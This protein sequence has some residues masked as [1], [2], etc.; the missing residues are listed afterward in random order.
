M[1]SFCGISFTNLSVTTFTLKFNI[2]GSGF[3]SPH[4]S[5]ALF[6]IWH[7]TAA[8]TMGRVSQ[9]S[10]RSLLGD[11]GQFLASLLVGPKAAASA[12]SRLTKTSRL[13]LY[14]LLYIIFSYIEN[15]E[16]LE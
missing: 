4:S 14:R 9:P 5:R 2:S 8:A 7:A 10:L 11:T 1:P 16:V 6:E 12:R 13:A 3:G 15:A